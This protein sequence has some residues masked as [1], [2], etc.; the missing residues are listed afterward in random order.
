[1]RTFNTFLFILTAFLLQSCE[2]S[3]TVGNKEDDRR[4]ETTKKI[5]RIYNEIKLQENGVKVE[6]AYLV[7]DDGENIPEGNVLDFTEP[8]KVK[9]VM[10]IEK[11]WKVIDGKSSI[12][13]SEK[14]EA[15]TGEVLLNEESLFGNRFPEGMPAKDARTVALT[16]SVNLKNPVQ[17]LTAFVVSFRVW[18]KNSE[19]F[20]TGS[21]K[22]YAK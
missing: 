8:V 19:A 6:K 16:A 18:D 15:E 14:I 1:M 13:A 4:K 3:C 2:F 22:L 5:S 9:M 11:G 17:P 12:D 21:Y 10:V 7:F 20:V